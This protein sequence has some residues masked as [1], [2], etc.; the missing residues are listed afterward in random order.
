MNSEQSAARRLRYEPA[1]LYHLAERTKTRGVDLTQAEGPWRAESR[2]IEHPGRAS[3][4]SIPVVTNET[5][6]VMVDTEQHALDVAGLLNWCG[7][8][9]LEPVPELTPPGD[10]NRSFSREPATA[11]AFHM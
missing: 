9:D 7:V 3:L 8:H 5:T 6:A 1:V 11:A 10:R 2:I 4:D